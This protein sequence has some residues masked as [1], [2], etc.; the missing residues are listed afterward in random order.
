MFGKQ[1]ITFL[2]FIL[3]AKLLTPY[4][5]GIYNYILA[6]IFFL[7]MF[8]DF[9]ISTATSKYVAEYNV[10]DRDKLRAVFF[11]SGLI[12]FTLTLIAT[13]LALAIGPSYLEDKYVYVLYLLPLV[14][15]APMTSLYDGIYRGLKKFKELAIISL[16]VGFISIFFVYFFVKSYGLTGALIAQ[17]IFYLLLFV[18]L[19]FGH[20]DFHFKI[21]REV[22][23]E[24]GKY[25][26]FVGL[27]DLGIFLYI[28]FDILVLGQFNYINEISYLSIANKVFMLLA[29]PFG[30]FS[31]V[32][33]PDITS[34][35][36]NKKYSEINTRLKK[37]FL[38]SFFIGSI[39]ALAAFILTKFMVTH[40]LPQYDNAYFYTF[41]WLLLAIFPIRVFGS[42][43][44][45]SFIIGAGQARVMTYNNIIFG[46]LNVAMDIIFI[47]IF[48]AI[49]VIFSTLILGYISVFVAYHYFVKLNNE[50]GV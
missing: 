15:L 45:T 42:I 29:L 2:I 40:F 10:T 19:F 8:G 11:N 47:F 35:Y 24:I 39:I 33:A 27:A 32:I 38:H 12:I 46:V 21:N 34:L 28:Q 14:F 44:A 30:I 9:G 17:N 4:E 41:F 22:M 31:Q 23:R 7:I 43:L 50:Q 3:C 20:R 25:S 16:V 26:L 13:L 49:G 18:G 5:F 36:A 48:G 37:Y 6:I 1:G